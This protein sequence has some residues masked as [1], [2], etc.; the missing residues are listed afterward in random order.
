M[1]NVKWRMENEQSNTDLNGFDLRPTPLY[2]VSGFSAGKSRL[3][4]ERIPEEATTRASRFQSMSQR[5]SV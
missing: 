4:R 3:A 5:P 1:G 2:S